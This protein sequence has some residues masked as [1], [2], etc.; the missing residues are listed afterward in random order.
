MEL[1][2]QNSELGSNSA[3]RFNFM[4]LYGWILD[5]LCYFESIFLFGLPKA[6]GLSRHLASSEGA[7]MAAAAELVEDLG[8]IFI[9]GA[10][11]SDGYG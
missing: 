6:V 1:R 10:A 5:H 9:G 3:N 7:L 4:A 11:A 2:S 8:A